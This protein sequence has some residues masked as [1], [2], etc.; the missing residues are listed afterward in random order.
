MMNQKTG[1]NLVSQGV[2]E[3]IIRLRQEGVEA[4]NSE[5]ER[6]LKAANK[7]ARRIIDKA[8]LQA[9]KR[10]SEAKKESDALLSGGKAAL[11][12]AMRDMVLEMK[13]T[14]TEGFKADVRRLIER[15]MEQPDII[16][17]LI[18]EIAG[19]VAKNVKIDDETELELILPK[20]VIDLEELQTSPETLEDSPLTEVVFGITR[21]MMIKGVSFSLSDELTNGM[22]VKLKDQ[23]VILDFTEQAVGAMLLQ[24]L[25]PRFRAILEGV[26]R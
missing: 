5:A 6:I 3:L 20:Q 16:K 11:K 22:Q 23:D 13:T 9:Q 24:H 18:L 7:E 15:E 26:V 1:D 19:K 25:Q 14:L 10:I 21:E 17:S 4:G 8:N 2:D 12:T